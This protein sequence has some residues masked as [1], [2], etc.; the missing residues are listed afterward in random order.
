MNWIYSQKYFFKNKRA[1][2][3]GFIPDIEVKNEV[4]R[5]HISI[6]ASVGR[7]D[8]VVFQ[9]LDARASDCA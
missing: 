1:R 4:Q 3:R 8:V 5:F 9:A 6:Y 2:Y 7:D